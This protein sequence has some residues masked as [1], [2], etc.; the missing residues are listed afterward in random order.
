MARQLTRRQMLQLTV[1]AGAACRYVNHGSPTSAPGPHKQF[2]PN[3]SS[4]R[5]FPP[6]LTVAARSE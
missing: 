5:A 3:P 1:L 6:P 2:L 4:R